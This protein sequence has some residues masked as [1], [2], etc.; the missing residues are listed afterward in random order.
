MLGRENA[1]VVLGAGALLGAGVTYWLMRRSDTK[2]KRPGQPA[3]A[4]IYLDHNASTPIDPEAAA[5]MQPYLWE[6]SLGNPSS[7]YFYGRRLKAA[8]ESSRAQVASLLNA[9]VSEVIFTSGGTESN[10]MAI[11][12]H[13]HHVAKS[14][15]R[16]GHII[17]S[18][19]EHPATKTVCEALESEGFTVSYVAVDR[20]GLLH[21]D[22]VEAAIQPGL[23]DLITI[24][25]ANSE[26][27]SIQPVHQISQVAQRHGAQLHLDAA[28]TVGKVPV[29]VQAM[30]VDFL[31]ICGHKLYAP[32]GSGGL[33]IK[34]PGKL[35]QVISGAGHEKGYRPGT[36]SVMHNVGL[37]EACNQ[38]QIHLE[39]RTLHTS[40]MRDLL[41]QMLVAGFPA[42]EINGPAD[43]AKRL[44]GTLS[45]G[46]PGVS[47][48]KVLRHVHEKVCCSAGS[49]C[50]SGGGVSAVLQAMEVRHGA[51][52]LRLSTGVYTTEQDI[53]SAYETI[54]E[55]LR[56]PTTWKLD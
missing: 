49:A 43:D 1:P 18:N 42:A 40:A 55:A 13:M 28:Q 7:D 54:A 47:S 6:Q 20:E 26:V 46:F 51:G 12:G 8:V 45:I 48:G 30:G 21:A 29:D 34:G 56:D 19:I 15:G 32:K 5:V 4:P 9:S 11:R 53:Q 10:N 24:M 3:G 33:Y 38:A 22:A 36:E 16:K 44:P 31:S 39:E 35:H 2:P 23:T 25:H 37:G 17:T 14:K 52:T 27:G 41:Q 50:H